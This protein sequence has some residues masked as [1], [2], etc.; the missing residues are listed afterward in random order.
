MI[1]NKGVCCIVLGLEENDPPLKFKTMTYKRF[2]SLDR[3]EALVKLG[4]V[5]LNNLLV[6][7]KAIEYCGIR[8]HNYRLSSNIFPLMTYDKAEI[9][10]MM[11][12]Q[13]YE[14]NE[15]LNS[16]AAMREKYDVR[17]SSH[18]DQFNVLASDNSEAVLR[19]IRELDFQGWFMS[20]IGCPLSREAPINIHVNRS[21]GG[22]EDEMKRV[23]DL[24][25][26]NY[27][28][29]LEDVTSR[30]VLENDDKPAGWTVKQ[31]FDYF[32]ETEIPIT[33]DYL[34]HK[35][36]P[37]TGHYAQ[38]GQ[39]F[40]LACETW[41]TKPII[42]LFHY[43]ES[44]PGD[45]N[46]RKHTDYASTLPNTYEKTIDLDFEFKMKEKSFANLL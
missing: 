22:S 44:I 31:L 14:I 4:D 25:Y 23:R 41:R 33:F 45:K 20:R 46:P 12:P 3:A 34:H 32:D 5:I 37:G 35:C 10:P 43:S 15:R 9:N 28:K 39:A 6:T 11:L 38:E 16:V 26:S 17:L 27:A 18:P 1:R 42:P 7:E 21:C 36:H 30:L 2:S 24:F 40:L 13:Y 8:K 29:L 19:T